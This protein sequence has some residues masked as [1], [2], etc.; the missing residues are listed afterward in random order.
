MKKHIPYMVAFGWMIA[1]A[2]LAF[3]DGLAWSGERTRSAYLHGCAQGDRIYLAENM[4]KDAVLYVMD[5]DGKVKDVSL[6]SSVKKGSVFAK[7]DYEDSLYGVLTDRASMEENSG[8]RYTIVQFDDQGRVTAQTP[9]YTM[10]QEGVLTGFSAEPKGFYLT[11]VLEDKT[12]AGA[13]FV[14]KE[15]LGSENSAEAASLKPEQT[16]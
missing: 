9:E 10:E 6:A 7:I 2:V 15:Q 4:E 5:A 14:G 13:Y 3:L 16:A 8:A 1:V 12:S 11:V